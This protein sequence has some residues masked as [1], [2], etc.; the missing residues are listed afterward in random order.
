M[1]LKYY[2]VII[3]ILSL[4]GCN[5]DMFV[6]LSPFRKLP[7]AENSGSNTNMRTLS[8]WWFCQD[9]TELSIDDVHERVKLKLA[10][11]YQSGC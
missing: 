3:S 2:T 11:D 6:I 5:E 1:L 7:G 10:D 4:H 8:K 9:E